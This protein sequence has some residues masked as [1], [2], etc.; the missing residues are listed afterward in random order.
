M[1]FDEEGDKGVEFVEGVEDAEE[2]AGMSMGCDGKQIS[3]GR[4][5]EGA[6]LLLR[7]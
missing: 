1:A 6:Q 2:V 3:K 7:Q 5:Y 4:R